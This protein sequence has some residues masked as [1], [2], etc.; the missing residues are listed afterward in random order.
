MPS[1]LCFQMLSI[2]QSQPNYIEHDVTVFVLDTLSMQLP[3]SSP[4]AITYLWLM[5]CARDFSQIR[6]GV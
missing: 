1:K 3:K 4:E 6:K 5:R 2:Q